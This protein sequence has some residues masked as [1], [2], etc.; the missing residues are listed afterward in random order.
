MKFTEESLEQAVIELF[1]EEGYAYISG[2]QITKKPHEVLITEDLKKYLISRYDDIT[3]S[4]LESIIRMLN[5]YPASDIY[6]SNKSI[7]KHISDGFILTREDR[8]KKDIFIEFIDYSKKENNIYKIVNQLEIHGAEKRIPDWVVYINGLPL[9]VLEFKTAI[10]EDTTIID[11]F[12]QL[13]VRYKRDIPELFKYN[14]FC[15]I[16]DWVNNKSGS[17]FSPYDFFYSWRKIDGNEP[18]ERDGI[19]SLFTMVHWLFQKDRLLDV[20]KNFIYFP[21]TS[22]NDSKIVCRY[23]QYYAANKLFENIKVSMKPEGN[24]KWG[25]YFGATGC[26]KSFT[27][28]YLSRLIM[29][30]VD[31]RSPTIII[32]TDRTDLD[33]QLSWQFTNAKDFIGDDTI[34][35]VESRKELRDYIQWRTA[36]WV[37]LTTIQKFSEDIELLSDRT[38]IIC[39]S[40]E[41]HR[42]QI[43]LD[44]KLKITSWWVEKTFGFAKYLHDSLP[45]ATYV[46]FTWTPVDATLDVFGRVVDAYTMKE[47]VEDKITVPI[48]YEWRA[49]KVTLD[50]QK[51]KEIENYYKLCEEKWANEYQIEESKKA[52]LQMEAIL[53]DPDRIRSVAIDFVEHYEKR[54]EEWATVKWKVMFVSSSRPI[55]FLLY[56]EIIKLRPDWGTIKLSDDWV[57]LSDKD[58]KEV[59]PMEKVKLIMTRWKDDA[60]DLYNAIGAKEDK[61][62]FDRQFKNEKS[63]FKIAI[64]VDMWLTGFD[65]PFLDTIYIDKP[66][67][68]HS[69]IQTISRVNRV[70]EWKEMWLVVDYIWIKSNMNVAL[71]KYGAVDENNFEDIGKAISVVKD[72]LDLLSKLFHKFETSEYFQ[73]SPLKKLEC[74]NRGAEF[75]QLTW[76]ME[77]RFMNIT[78]KLRS[79]YN[80]CCSTE[81]ISDEEKD[82]IHFYLAIRAIIHKLTKWDAPDTAK[83]NA[84]VREMINEAII[85]EWVEEIFKLWKES[86]KTSDIFSDEYL[87]MVNKIKLPNTKIKLLQ[88]LLSKAIWEYKKTNKLKWVDFSKKFKELVEKYNERKEA[89]ALAHDVLEDVADQFASLFNELRTDRDSFIEMG[90]DYEEKAFYDILKSIAEKYKFEYPHEKLLILARSIKKIVDDKSRYA[91]WSHREDIKAELKVDLI[92][93]LADNDYPPVTKDDVFK[94]IFEQAEN[95]K[96]YSNE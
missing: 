1:E 23:P 93:I 36:W 30:S 2:E 25:T 19:D 41:A 84:R 82:L 15:V 4:E 21:D 32:I 17:L 3:I 75:V 69:L 26:G 5:A 61:K 73:W 67:Q 38:N 10:K 20:I 85:S 65:V 27:M 31:F 81:E 37:F 18:I 45:N 66:L 96:K 64:V 79:A 57:V 87:A 76:D 47:S 44:Q 50:S 53:W 46:W 63:N 90:I 80:L 71:K 40:D 48:V 56:K 95:F 14:A 59:K 62:E 6:E 16:S 11:A 72:Q 60:P 29:R 42:T 24:G 9:V 8:S 55:A 89:E 13:T 12:T 91:W 78:K 33:D 39:I 49:A 51:L 94:E 74:L 92:L 88:Y 54:I 86:E 70:Y 22:K 34:V 52:V 35:S 58:K 83:M 68:Q 77:K 43:N 28:L 7:M